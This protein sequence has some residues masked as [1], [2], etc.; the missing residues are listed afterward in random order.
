MFLRLLVNPAEY[1]VVDSSASTRADYD[2]IKEI[3]HNTSEEA[4]NPH[5]NGLIT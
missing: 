5:C 3:E 4:I 1:E 2:K